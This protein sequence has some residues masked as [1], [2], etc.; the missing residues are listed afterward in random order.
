MVNRGLAV[1]MRSTDV[2]LTP[3]LLAKPLIAVFVLA[4]IVGMMTEYRTACAVLAGGLIAWLSQAYFAKRLHAVVLKGDDKTFM[5]VFYRA[6]WRKL[7]LAAVLFV[8]AIKVAHAPG[9][10]LLGSYA[11]IQM[12][13]MLW[14]LRCSKTA[15]FEF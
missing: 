1:G 11:L 14:L 6:E 10:P 2:R 5:R 4:G 15:L 12:G 7:A 13:W 3:A 8:L 9:L